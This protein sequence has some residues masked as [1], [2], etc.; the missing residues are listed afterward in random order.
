MT[1]GLHDKFETAVDAVKE[2]FKAAVD[3]KGFDV[4]G[5]G[6]ES[7]WMTDGE[8]L[9]KYS[10]DGMNLQIFPIKGIK[11]GGHFNLSNKEVIR[12]KVSP[13]PTVSTVFV[14]KAGHR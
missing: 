9:V 8:V 10:P 7:P 3:D 13:A 6:L 1:C 12:K 11:S 2:A 14:K 5:S 4:K